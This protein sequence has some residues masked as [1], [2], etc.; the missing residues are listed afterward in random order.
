M[1]NINISHKVEHNFWKNKFEKLI[2]FLHSKIH[3]WFDKDDKYIDVVNDM[4]QE[5]DLNDEDIQDLD[6]SKNDDLEI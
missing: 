1:Q 3:N 2:D 5:N 4:Y 6:L